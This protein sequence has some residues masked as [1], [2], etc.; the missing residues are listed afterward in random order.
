MCW[1]PWKLQ[2]LHLRMTSHTVGAHVVLD[3]KPQHSG[4]LGS[5]QVS[6]GMFALLDACPAIL[7]CADIVLTLLHPCRQQD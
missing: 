4:L 7:P 1:P 2:I 5:A 3:F 6:P